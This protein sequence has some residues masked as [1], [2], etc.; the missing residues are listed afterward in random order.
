MNEQYTIGIDGG[1]TNLP[2]I[3]VRPDLTIVGRANAGTANPNVIGH[4]ETMRQRLC[5][6]TPEVA[7]TGGLW[8]SDNL[9]IW[10]LCQHLGLSN[11]P[12]PRYTPVVGAALL[13]LQHLKQRV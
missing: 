3:V 8:T 7:F 11:I 6:D 12:Q 1:G 10:T 5:M 9:L 4:V 13:A 2:V